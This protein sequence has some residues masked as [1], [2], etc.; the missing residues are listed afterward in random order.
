MVNRILLDMIKYNTNDA[1]RI[2]HA[3]KVYSLAKCIGSC[4]GLSGAEL[5]TLEIAAILHD[6]GIHKSEKKYGSSAGKYQEIE[7]PPIAKQLLQT[8]HLKT[9]MLNRI[10]F[11]I[12]HHHTY[13]QIDGLDY[14]ALIEADFIVNFEEE[15]ASTKAITACK[16]KLF[17]TQTG[18]QLL[19]NIL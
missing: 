14:Q 11:L 18:S 7:G 4:E 1:R 17:K 8:Y 12:S 5:T 10:L 3:L 6:I 2:N 13:S 15:H 19:S 9:P 16:N